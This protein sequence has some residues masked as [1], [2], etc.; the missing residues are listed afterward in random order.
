MQEALHAVNVPVV[1]TGTSS[2]FL[3]PAATDWLTLLDALGQ[4]HRPTL[5]RAAALTDFL[6]WSAARLATAPDAEFDRLALQ[7][8]GWAA[9]LAERGVAALMEQIWGSTGIVARVLAREDGERHLTDLRHIGEALHA[10]AVG[11]R[12]GVAFLTAWLRTR[13]RDARTDPSEE[14][15]RR[16]ETD[17][18]A[19][20]VIT[21]H[22]AKGLE[23]PVV[24]APSLWDRNVQTSLETLRLHDDDG[25][26][27][28]DVGGATGP[29]FG[30]RRARH[31]VEEEGESLRLAY[32]ALTRARS[33]V[34]VHW[35]ASRNTAG[36]PLH[37]LLFAPRGVDGTLGA[38]GN[39]GTDREVMAHLDRL[40]A[41]AG[42][43]VSIEPL[44]PD[45]PPEPWQ[46]P[47]ATTPPLAART[48]DRELDRAWSRVSYTA[49]TAVAHAAP[50]TTDPAGALSEPDLP[51]VLDEPDVVAP[52][53][54]TAGC[55]DGTRGKRR[56]RLPSGPPLPDT[57]TTF[58]S[59]LAHLPGGTTFGTV[60]HAM[61]ESVDFTDPDLATALTRAAT[62]AGAERLGFAADDVAQSLL[63]A[64]RTPLGPLT[65]GRALVDIPAPDVLRELE[66]ELPLAG[67]DTPHGAATLT[68]VAGL[69]DRH[70]PPGDPLRGYAADLAG[71]A[72]AGDR[73]LRGFLT[74]SIDAV[75]R[76]PGSTPRFVV[77]DYKTNWLGAGR[78]GGGPDQEPLTAWDYR[79]TAMAAT[80]RAAHYPL[81]ALLYSAALHR[82]LRWRLAGYEAS[83]HL[84]GVLYLFVRGMCGP[85]T[86]VV[87][88]MTC[89]VFPWRPPAAL[90]CELSDLLDRQ[91]AR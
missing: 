24:Y 75:L 14:R 91:E 36:S 48:F 53:P 62:T 76:I 15:G 84:G 12:G 11:N 79:G 70:L 45:R 32:V 82:F 4:P 16:L 26:R 52:P 59:P 66:F 29:A 69:L 13:I 65:G 86:P 77:V 64:L 23:F 7:V 56:R 50:R 31:W 80:M 20:Q 88:G 27:I 81:Q 10:A 19:V 33:Q 18:Q 22:R 3:T 40:A 85:E 73:V 71:L 39:V 49:L 38:R 8:R 46:P 61:L 5:A 58:P 6:G 87:D 37:R 47:V 35:A 83:V 78:A 42:G 43:Q 90:V 67:G 74:G 72:G 21:T 30:H 63:P 89:G 55:G 1:L 2:V 28:L 9:V 25:A 51:G 44:L 34:V 54:P 41:G 68:G 57:A 17:A 60:V